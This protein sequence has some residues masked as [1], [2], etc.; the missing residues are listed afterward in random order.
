MN[1]TTGTVKWYDPMSGYGFLTPAE[2]GAD[3]FVH[4]SA[5]HGT[6]MKMLSPGDRVEFEVQETE[7]GPVAEG[8]VRSV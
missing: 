2:P 6:G 1:R 3:V 5:V 4:H 8:V 7:N